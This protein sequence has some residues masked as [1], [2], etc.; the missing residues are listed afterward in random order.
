MTTVSTVP[1][2]V[3][4][5]AYGGDTLTITVTAD[6]SVTAGMH[7]D[8]EIRSTRDDE[9]FDA[10]F[11]IKEPVVAG[12]PATLTLSAVDSSRLVNTAPIVERRAP[13]GALRSIQQYVGVWD[14]QVSN[15]HL[16]PVRTLVQGSIT[17]ELDV[18]RPT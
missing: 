10:T 17:I 11:S 8:A 3:D 13:D 15:N 18:T 6:A 5:K 1:M 16:D 9:T 4:I 12:D 7:W 14:C 2:I